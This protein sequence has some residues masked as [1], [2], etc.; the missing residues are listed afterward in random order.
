MAVYKTW[1]TGTGNGM[2]E[3]WGM[4]KMLHSKICCQTLPGMSSNILGNVTKHS[5]ECPE[6]LQGMSPNTLLNV[7]KHSGECGQTFPGMLSNIPGY[8]TKHSKKCPQT[9]RGVSPNIRGMSPN[10]SGN[11]LKHCRDCRQT[12]YMQNGVTKYFTQNS[13]E[14]INTLLHTFVKFGIITE[15]KLI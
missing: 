3:T 11:G 14:K 1:N 5:R 9:F 2:R 8:L 4:G 10:I 12:H 7:P 6:T 13:A 15:L